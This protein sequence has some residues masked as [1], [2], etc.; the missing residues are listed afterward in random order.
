M[1]LENAGKD[2][3]REVMANFQ[4]NVTAHTLIVFVHDLAER[5]RVSAGHELSRGNTPIPFPFLNLVV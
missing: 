2:I 3:F 4:G 1:I 5:E